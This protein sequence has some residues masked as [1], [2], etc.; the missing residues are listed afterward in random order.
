MHANVY[1]VLTIY[2]IAL[3]SWENVRSIIIAHL[4]IIL[5][6]VG[7][8]QFCSRSLLYILWVKLNIEYMNRNEMEESR[9]T[10]KNTKSS[11][12]LWYCNRFPLI[13]ILVQRFYVV[14]YFIGSFADLLFFT[15]WIL[16]M[17]FRQ[18]S[19]LKCS[20]VIDQCV[21]SRPVVRSSEHSY[22]YRLN[23]RHQLLCILTDCRWVKM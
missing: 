14:S 22:V 16:T 8:I 2:T 7:S 11:A 21:T 9:S 10:N 18:F 3:W 13:E 19:S 23:H 20:V 6:Q 15:R 5:I 1:F 12:I 4:Y 17:S